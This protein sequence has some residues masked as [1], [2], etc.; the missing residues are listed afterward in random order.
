MKRVGRFFTS[1]VVSLLLICGSL[2]IAA[3]GQTLD[4][5]RIDDIERFQSQGDLAATEAAAQ[6]LLS[7]AADSPEYQAW[8]RIKLAEVQL[9]KGLQGSA[10]EQLRDVVTLAQ[11]AHPEPANWARIRLAQTLVHTRSINDAMQVCEAVIADHAA[12]RANDQQGTWA[13]ITKG[14]A[15]LADKQNEQAT[16]ALKMSAAL[17]ADQY[18]DLVY[19][20]E[21]DVGETYRQWGDQIQRAGGSWGPLHEQALAHYKTA[22]DVAQQ[23]GLPQQKSDMA[24]LQVGS[25]MRHLGMRDKGIAWLRMGISDPAVLSNT[26]WL[27]AQRIA[28]F[29]APSEAESWYKFLAAPQT[30]P[31]PTESIVQSVMRMTPQ[32]ASSE[33]KDAFDR[34]YWLGRLYEDQ[35]R[36]TDAIG[37]YQTGLAIAS[38]PR[39]RGMGYLAHS[40]CLMALATIARQRGEIAESEAYKAEADQAA[41]AG[42]DAWTNIAIGAAEQAAHEAIENVWFCCLVMHQTVKAV[43]S[44]DQIL[45]GTDPE[46]DPSKYA[47]AQYTLMQC[48]AQ[49]GSMGRA[50]QIA[51]EIW[52]RFH[53]CPRT[54]VQHIRTATLLKAVPYTLHEKELE[55]AGRFLDELEPRADERFAK[56]IAYYRG[57]LSP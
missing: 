35:G 19:E 27:L 7:D 1:S 5:S 30:A 13:L 37:Q 53:V 43:D 40:R 24:R 29:F 57:Q 25:E 18:P 39:E 48:Y 26:D 45:Q 34:Y 6:Q 14:R 32:R 49:G 28:S 31:D 47:F 16:D 56:Q 38:T 52:H 50:L 42:A 2:P 20:S 10:I 9:G 3:Q 8:A 55:L 21:F 54:D 15:L 23:A 17:A 51:Q 44:L 36:R 22:L 46:V 33:T 4:R 11:A 12:G 41:D